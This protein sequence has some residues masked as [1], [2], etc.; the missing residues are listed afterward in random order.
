MVQPDRSQTDLAG[1][2]GHEFADP[3][4]LRRALTHRSWEAEQDES[5][6]ERLEFLGDAVLGLAV[7]DHVFATRPDMAEGLLAKTRA[8]VVSADALAEVALELDIG[9]ALLLGKGE[10]SS[11]G[12]TKPSILA[13]A[14]EA[15]I[16]AVYVDAG[17]IPARRLVL[18]LFGEKIE[19]AAMGPGIDDHKTRL[20]ELAA[21]DHGSVPRYEVC[22]SGPDHDRR[23]TARAVFEDRTWGH[24]EGRSKKEAEQAAAAS[25]LAE[26]RSSQSDAD[27]RGK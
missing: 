24:G 4:L 11:G 23:F 19:A 15:L 6:N 20:Q 17:W 3:A 9:S 12:R 8:D 14:L 5:S 13:D 25:A 26:M 18:S 16:G 1:R 10:D 27:R 7:A 22:S 21:R 2:L